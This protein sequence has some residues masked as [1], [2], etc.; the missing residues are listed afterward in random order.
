MPERHHYEEPIG[1]SSEQPKKPE[2]SREAFLERMKAKTN[3]EWDRS[4]EDIERLGQLLKVGYQESRARQLRE[5][6]L[7]DTKVARMLDA[8]E[9]AFA[10]I[11]EKSKG[12]KRDPLQ[13]ARELEETREF[14]KRVT[15]THRGEGDG[16]E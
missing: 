7:N 1:H 13:E 16:A 15:E 8:E 4:P 14:L 12:K 9:A 6:G 3:E 2:E 11:A 5:W 10:R